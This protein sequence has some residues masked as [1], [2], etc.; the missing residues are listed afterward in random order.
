[1][2]DSILIDGLERNGSLF[3]YQ[4]RTSFLK[5]EVSGVA[6]T[7]PLK[8]DAFQHPSTILEIEALEDS[9]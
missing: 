6:S 9:S 2:V 4:N 3:E 5:D 1:M 7:M 8:S